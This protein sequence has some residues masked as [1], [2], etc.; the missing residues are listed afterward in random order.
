LSE[1]FLLTPR[2]T[3]PGMLQHVHRSSCKV[4]VILV[5]FYKTRFLYNFRKILKYQISLKSFQ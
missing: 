1:T 2:S 4:P 3:Q 5:R